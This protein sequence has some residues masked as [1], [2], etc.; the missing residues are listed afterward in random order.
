MKTFI[1]QYRISFTDGT[2]FAKTMR[3]KN[4]YGGAHAQSRL[5]DY[6]KRKH[7]DFSA[8]TVYNCKEDMFGDMG[9]V[10]DVF[11]DI[12]GTKK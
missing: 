6:L 12:F 10:G 9:A 2:S 3:I 5:E 1:I 8:L 4:C 7:P 11:R